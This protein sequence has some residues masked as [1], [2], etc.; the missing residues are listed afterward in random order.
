LDCLKDGDPII[1]AGAAEALGDIGDVSAVDSI[2]A[3]AK[4]SKALIPPTAAKSDG[5]LN[6]RS[7]NDII[8]ENAIKSLGKLGDRKA[9][10]HLRAML[11]EWELN[12][13]LGESLK[14]LGWKPETEREK[15]YVLIGGHDKKRLEEQWDSFKP[16]LLED[17]K[18]GD[19]K[20]IYN[21]ICSIV[22]LGR[23]EMVD[24]LLQVLR[25]NGTRIIAEIYLNSG[26]LRLRVEAE[27]WAKKNGYQIAPGGSGGASWKSW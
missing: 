22:S 11:P 3:V 4:D 13:V 27:S 6:G 9:I 18:S 26:N 10:V 5:A 24:D 17:V 1:R 15:L 8:R 25:E 21:A 2:I 23:E 14:L 19:R 7:Y 12:K 16:L 20:R